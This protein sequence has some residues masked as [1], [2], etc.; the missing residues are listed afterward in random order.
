MWSLTFEPATTNVTVQLL[1]TDPNNI[2]G[3]KT[4]LDQD[5]AILTFGVDAQGVKDGTYDFTDSTDANGKSNLIATQRVQ[6]GLKYAK[7]YSLKGQ[8]FRKG[9][10]PYSPPAVAT[11]AILSIS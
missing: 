1:W 3:P 11:Q 4:Q 7:T 10:L 9:T 2:T 8:A 6:G 5:D